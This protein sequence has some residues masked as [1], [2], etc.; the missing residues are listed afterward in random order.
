V[1]RRVSIDQSGFRESLLVEGPAGTLIRPLIQ[2]CRMKC[3]G[4]DAACTGG[5][6]EPSSLLTGTLYCCT[7]AM[8]HALVK[9]YLGSYTL[10]VLQ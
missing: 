10:A 2:D 3:S 6:G 1:L 8:V 4:D 7:A 9:T 5:A